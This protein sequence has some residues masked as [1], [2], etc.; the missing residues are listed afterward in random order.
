MAS[1]NLIEKE[2]EAIEEIE[3]LLDPKIPTEYP[4]EQKELHREKFEKWLN[5]KYKSDNAETLEKK[6]TT[7]IINKAKY[8]WIKDVL[9]GEKKLETPIEKFKFN[10]KNILS[11]MVVMGLYIRQL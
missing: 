11:W 5:G 9:L 6:S 3:E 7:Y 2:I 10:K 4:N 8:D 1:N